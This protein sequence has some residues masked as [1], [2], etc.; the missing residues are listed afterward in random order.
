MTLFTSV[1]LRQKFLF[2]MSV[3]FILVLT[4][5]IYFIYSLRIIDASA[6]HQ[7]I[8]NQIEKT[9]LVREIQHLH[10]I[11]DV[12]T[13][14]SKNNAGKLQATTNPT[15]CDFGKWYYSDELNDVIKQF[16]R[17]GTVLRGLAAPHET[18][19]T[20]ATHIEQL[21]N[22]GNL[23]EAQTIF[24]QVTLPAFNQV[25]SHLATVHTLLEQ[26][27]AAL[28]AAEDAATK[29]A[30]LFAMVLGAAAS[31]SMLWLGIVLYKSV[32]RPIQI[33]STFAENCRKGIKSTLPFKRNDEI[34]ILA[35][36]LS[37]LTENLNRQLAFSSGVLNGI[38][39]PCSVFS[40]EDKTVFTN[41][42]MVNL[43]ERAGNPKDFY[44]MPSGEYIWGDRNKPT[45][46]TIALR[47]NR[48]VQVERE[49]RT[50]KGNSRF[51]QVT[52]APFNDVQGNLLGTLSV[53]NDITDIMHK[54]HEVENVNQRIV[55]LANSAHGVAHN[56]SSAST[57][58][59]VQVEQASQGALVQSE[60]L[61]DTTTAMLQM[62]ATV[63]EVATSA[64]NAATNADE[65][66]N[67]AQQGLSAVQTVISS[68]AE[69]NTVARMLKE[70]MEGLGEQTRNIGSILSVITD[71]ADQTNLLALNAAIEAARAGD[72]G[73]GFAVVADE[74][75][76]LAEKT[77]MATKEVRDVITGIQSGTQATM[78][79]AD[80]ASEKVSLAIDQAETAGTTLNSIVHL[81]E[82]VAS[83]IHSIAAAAEQQAYTS[84]TITQSLESV[85]LV[86]SETAMAMQQASHAV[87]NLAEQAL[88]LNGL[89]AELA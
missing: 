58:I 51:V 35:K 10:W 56:V 31:I 23:L 36:S 52:S 88:Q 30:T 43:L 60:R 34:G 54:Q 22:E 83:K 28:R 59:S 53:W 13:Y 63:T 84:T 67:T 78:F 16:P 79:N 27:L 42:H 47:E 87:E 19:H 64:S 7:R 74:V 73:R 76:N 25:T 69:V 12:S 32:L 1:S 5:A 77:V 62:N 9:L 68:I 85:R 50:H 39:V 72:Y 89:I 37:E 20:S 48:L 61:T 29:Q 14:I 15:Q 38:T 49:V 45:A 11:N 3:A 17:L 70:Q 71:I 18:L 81:V 66:R 24:E 44:G 8:A 21:T 40:I 65:A 82:G 46:S 55:T 86:S 4:S 41:K 26:D 80:T 33:I 75:R 2:L 57:E 6:Q